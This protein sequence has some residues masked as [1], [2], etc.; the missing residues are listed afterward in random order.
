MYYQTSGET[1]RLTT[2]GIFHSDRGSLFA[3]LGCSNDRLAGNRAGNG[4]SWL[5]PQVDTL[6]GNPFC[7]P[8]METVEMMQ[9]FSRMPYPEQWRSLQRILTWGLLLLWF[10]GGHKMFLPRLQVA[11]SHLQELC[12][13][14]IHCLGLVQNWSRFDF[15]TLKGNVGSGKTQNFTIF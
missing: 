7:T 10:L 2:A 8:T 5:P 15:I 4:S 14:C 12:W 9:H 6:I 13:P 1:C 3:V 11:Y